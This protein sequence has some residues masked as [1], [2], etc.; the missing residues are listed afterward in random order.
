MNRLVFFLLLTQGTFLSASAELT[1]Q[2]D[3]LQ[4]NLH[5]VRVTD[6]Q[7]KP[8]DA[9]FPGNERIYG[10][11]F[12]KTPA[13]LGEVDIMRTVRQLPGIQSVSEGNSGVYVRGGS[14]GQNLFLLDDMELL[15]PTHLMGVFSVFNP[16]TTSHVS[17]YKGQAPVDLQGR[18]ASTI[19]VVS[20]NPT[21]ENEGFEV[22]VGT[23]TTSLSWIGSLDDGRLDITTGLRRSYLEAI[24]A[25]VS[26]FLNDEQ[27]YFKNNNYRFYDFNGKATYHVNQQTDL[28]LSWYTGKDNFTFTNRDMGYL[29]STRWGN[30]ALTLRLSTRKPTGTAF[31]SALAY[32]STHSGFNGDI[33]SY[34]IYA[35]SYFKELQWKNRWEFLWKE[36]RIQV[37]AT[38]SGQHTMPL[39]MV[40]NYDSD[41]LVQ[42]QQYKNAVGVLYAGDYFSALSGR[43]NG[44]AGLR[45]TANLPL[46]NP[47]HL[48]YNLSP[49]VSLSYRMTPEQ[50]FKLSA[51]INDQHVHLA[52]LGSIP[53]P[54]DIWTPVTTE[55]PPET[56][57]Q[58]TLGYM[59]MLGHG[60][61]S[62]EI[63]GKR[64]YNQL[65]F[66]IITDNENVCDFEDRFFHGK[67]LAYGIDV[68]LDTRRG[69]FTGTL[70]YSYSR[71]LRS[72]PDILSG[73]WFND[74]YDRPHDVNLTVSYTFNKTWDVAAN[75]VYASGSNMNLPAG[76]WWLMGQIMNDY[77]TFNGFR[78]PAYHR[79]DV[80]AN[81][82]LK[83]RRL[84]SSVVNFSVI[85]LYNRANPYFAYFKVYQ[86]ENRYNLNIQTYQ[87]SLFPILPSV[88]WRFSF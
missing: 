17:V 86:D 45:F 73:N 28:T 62:V 38:L 12:S 60:S 25:I 80:S 41:S 33:I 19:A 13:L 63:Y 53:L 75:W 39:D 54:N 23:M 70:S 87:V 83:S 15:N 47:R 68:S 35:N 64:L 6:E 82:H 9:T 42:Y 34:D 57:S 40:L 46:N 50:S 49:V 59:R 1:V 21:P 8:L 36:H 78:L 61:L 58:L 65:I 22:N 10:K 76:R 37:G 85:N 81:W 88:S 24:G 55:L 14:A 29:A 44:Y 31:E 51:S 20:K 84:K 77:Q 4:K 30:D 56:S 67:G 71:S 72:Y 7:R 32:H 52:A 43:L 74:K 11:D 48:L 27:N 66:N 16:I 2:T 69:P 26:P 3:T 79:L 18:L 5:E